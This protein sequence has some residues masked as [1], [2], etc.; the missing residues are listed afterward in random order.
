M[1][2]IFIDT[3]FTDVM[4]PRLISIGL[5]TAGGEQLYVALEINDWGGA[6]ACTEF[7]QEEVLPK[8]VEL[9]PVVLS[10]KAAGQ[11]I[12]DWLQREFS[13]RQR[14]FYDSGQQEI[15]VET[16]SPT[17][18]IECISDAVID[19]T[20]LKELL[21]SVPSWLTFSLVQNKL[22]GGPLAQLFAGIDE[23]FRQ[24]PEQRHHALHDA[25]ALRA[26]WMQVQQRR[27]L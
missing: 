16:M 15:N 12:H 9:N 14:N 2:H 17:L 13:R 18:Q 4:N 25:R 27:F 1:R 8:L 11:H 10:R 21:P 6:N 19:A 22:H 7:V 23:H 5:I 20:L 3:E 24:Q 26:A